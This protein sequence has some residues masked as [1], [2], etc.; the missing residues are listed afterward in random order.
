MYDVK[1]YLEKQAE[2]NDDYI[3]FVM[4]ETEIQDIDNETDWAL[5]EMKYKLLYGEKYEK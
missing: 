4:K 1:K 5:A 2:V 3:P